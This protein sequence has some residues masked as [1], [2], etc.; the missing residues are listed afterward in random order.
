MSKCRKGVLVGGGGGLAL[1]VVN[2]VV[3][4]EDPLIDIVAVCVRSLTSD[5]LASEV[6]GNDDTVVDTVVDVVVDT[7][8]DTVV[9]VCVYVL[10]PVEVDEVIVVVNPPPHRD[11]PVQVSYNLRG[12][13]MPAPP[14]EQPSRGLEVSPCLA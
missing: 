14:N 7:V 1:L 13:K 5:A 6:S 10:A 8:V 11:A 12:A 4:R 3:V 2:V 9:E